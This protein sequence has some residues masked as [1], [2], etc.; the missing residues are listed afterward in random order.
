[1]R[2]ILTALAATTVLLTF[3]GCDTELIPL[4]DTPATRPQTVVPAQSG[5]TI[6]V[7]SFNIQVFGVSKLGK[8][9]VM[10]VLARV[11]R[12]FDVVAIQEI[13]SK[14]TTVL[15]KFVDLINADGSHYDYVIGPRLG[16]ERLHQ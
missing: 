10:D 4:H 3:A 5:E 8:P 2:S 13:R 11:V 7:A 16:G 14:D 9:D 12:K 1:M 6:T 15:P